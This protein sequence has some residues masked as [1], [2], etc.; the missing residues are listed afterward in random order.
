MLDGFFVSWRV[1]LAANRYT[2]RKSSSLVLLL[3]QI[4]FSRNC[5]GSS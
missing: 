4:G 2:V 1:D 5:V 3:L